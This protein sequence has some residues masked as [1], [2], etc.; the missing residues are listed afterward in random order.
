[1]P[2]PLL[3]KHRATLESALDAIATRGYW[4]AFPEMPS[5]KLYGEAAPDEGKRA[6]E[7]HLGKPFELGQPGQTGWHGG[8][9]SPYGV[10]LDVRYPVCDPETLIAAGLEAMKG[11]QA[12]GAD[13]R[14]GICLEI[15][16]RLNKQSFEIAHA[17]MMTTGQ[18]WMMAFQ[19]GGPHAQDRGLEAVTYAWREQSFVPAETTWEKP[20]G[21]NPALVMK[22]HFQIVGRGVGLV[23]G[24]GT[25]PTWNTYPGL[26]AAL[27]TGNAVIVKAHSN[28]ILPAAITVRTIR[29]VL[30]ENGIDPNLVSL[31]VA[32]QRSVTQA[33]ATHPAVQSVDF[34]GSNVFGQWLIDNCRQAQ[35]YAELAGVNNI[36][37]DSTDSY[38]A[39]LGN[40]AFTL[41]L[42]SGQMC[43]T[44]QAIFVPAGG[45][46]T[47]DGHKS[48]D[49][50]C[51][52]LA[53]AV[54]RF[55]SKPEV[56]HAVLGAIQSADTAE[57]IDIAN[58]GALGKVVLASQKLDN[59][60]F[61]GAKVRTPVLLA[62]DAADEKAYMEERFGPI[63]FIVKVADTAAGI[64]L[65]ER[66]VRTHGALTV[67]LYSTRQD[68]IDAMTEATWRGKVA[69]SINLTGGV[70][71][72]QSA[73]F[74][75]YHG[76]GGNPSANASYSDSAF[77][78]NRFRVVQ[79]RYH[80]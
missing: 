39:M 80:V 58:S 8:E 10:A 6:F 43:T 74:S 14:T 24:C 68:V 17:V 16:Q 69:L 4:S 41:S 66:V 45:I 15:L 33:L 51:A 72:N 47:E 5:P 27:A 26:F 59:P 21:K 70:F 55:L 3:E 63:S 23:I 76:T 46:D 38:K 52:D 48:Y 42:Y 34:T 32:T 20:Q 77:V 71:V 11:W 29:T 2:H 62:C 37:I 60:E 64:A 25:F 40:L 12:V 54:E 75:D 28:A 65:S 9:S 44:S 13:G 56:A 36:V 79:R 73:A 7:A 35:V 67:G 30:A 57:R 31:C 18:G 49:E 1:M 19:A 50:V 61:P 22:K 53:R 78:A